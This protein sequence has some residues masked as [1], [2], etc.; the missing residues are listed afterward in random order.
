[1]SVHR[2]RTRKMKQITKLR[3]RCKHECILDSGQT[4]HGREGKTCLSH[5]QSWD[6]WVVMWEKETAV[7]HLKP[8]I[9]IISSCI[10]HVKQNN[11][12]LEVNI[13]EYLHDLTVGQDFL[14]RTLKA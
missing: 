1:M 2:E 13:E 7:S 6:N 10:T 11:K 5:N 12:T 14:N 8:C 9:E 3:S 4:G